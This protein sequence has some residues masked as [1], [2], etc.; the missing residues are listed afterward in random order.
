M[1]P[2]Y[3]L[4]KEQRELLYHHLVNLLSTPHEIIH[5]VFHGDTTEFL[6]YIAFLDPRRLIDIDEMPGN[7]T[8]FEER[9]G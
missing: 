2:G 1:P 7:A 6:D 9:Y 8:Q 3:P 4:S 5:Q